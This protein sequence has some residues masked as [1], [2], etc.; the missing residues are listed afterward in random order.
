MLGTAAASTHRCRKR[1]KALH[2][3]LGDIR[4]GLRELADERS[5]FEYGNCFLKAINVIR[6]QDHR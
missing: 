2:A 5:I 1:V 4:L 3:T 6:G